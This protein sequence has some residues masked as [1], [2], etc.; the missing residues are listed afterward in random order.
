MEL[1]CSNHYGIHLVFVPANCTSQLQVADVVLQRPF[2]HGVR[3]RF[4]GW[5]AQILKEQIES[6]ELVGLSPFLKM[7]SIKPLCLQW[8]IES[9]NKLADPVGRQYIQMGWHTCCVSLFDVHDPVK[10]VMVM[11]EVLLK[12]LEAMVIPEETEEI[13]EEAD[14]DDEEDEDDDKDQLDVMKERAYGTRKSDRKRVAAHA[15][16]FQLNSQQIAMSE[17]SDH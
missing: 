16:G 14:D 11:E 17:D 2:K 10:R 9:W 4:N 13:D 15:F 6:G 7:S 5:A 3:Q 8:I 1:A 12:E